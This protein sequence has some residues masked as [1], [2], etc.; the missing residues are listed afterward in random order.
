MKDKMFLS[1]D[2][3]LPDEL[4]Q[5]QLYINNLLNI[6]ESTRVTNTKYQEKYNNIKCPKCNGTNIIKNGHKNET[7]RY[8]CKECN[9]FF[10]ISTKTLSSHIKINFNI[11]ITIMKN[12]LDGKNLEDTS[13]DTKISIREV[14]NIRIKIMDTLKIFR[15]KTI[16]SG[17][18]EMDEKYISLSFKGT[19]KDKMP[20]ESKKSSH[21][22][23]ASGISKEDV[24]ILGAIDE[25]DNLLL[26][27]SGLASAGIKDLKNGYDG[28][29]KEGSTIITDEKKSYIKFAKDN[30]LNLKQIKSGN[31]ST[32]DGYNINTLNQVFSELDKYIANF[33]GL[34]T[35]HLQQ[36]LDFFVYRKHLRYT[37]EY[38][39]QSKEL[40]LELI[41][42]NSNLINDKI[43]KTKMPIDVDNIYGVNFK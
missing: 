2:L 20:R 35:R 22:N 25:N 40:Y 24:C 41:K 23:T 39:K 12:M 43:C 1:L 15:E 31:H 29:I 5:I 13:K 6:K 16:L 11:L 4:E 27:V 14:Y 19:R 28:L 3:L 9:T 32:K 7:Q 37:I 42:G 38:I 17:I 18:I 26:I 36:Y 30:K 21:D 8:K 33:N 34:S 10:S